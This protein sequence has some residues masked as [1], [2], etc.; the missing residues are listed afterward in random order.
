MSDLAKLRI[1]DDPA[2][3]NALSWYLEVAENGAPPSF[4]LL[5]PSPPG[6]ILRRKARMRS[7]PSL[8]A[9]RRIFWRAGGRSAP[10]RGCHRHRT[11]QASWSYVA[12]SH[13]ACLAIAISVHGIA[14]STA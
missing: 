11:D 7:G 2:I 3:F 1:W 5:R 10:A 14:A 6:S 4:V 12:S 9:S 8:S 13:T